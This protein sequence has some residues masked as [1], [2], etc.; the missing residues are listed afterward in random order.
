MTT[1]INDLTG[2]Y[3]AHGEFDD[4]NA[5]MTNVLLEGTLTLGAQLP[6]KKKKC[7]KITVADSKITIEKG[8]DGDTPCPAFL[9]SD[10][11]KQLVG[12]KDLTA[13]STKHE[14]D[15]GTSGIF[16]TPASTK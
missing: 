14:I 4:T 7:V 9:K 3:T 1:L 10:T 5:K 15:L 6:V 12:N 13:N 2:Y 16:G 8:E 11:F